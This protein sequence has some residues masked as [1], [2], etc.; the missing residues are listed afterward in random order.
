VLLRLEKE[1]GIVIRFIVGNSADPEEQ[2]SLDSEEERY[3][4][5][6]RLPITVLPFLTVAMFIPRRSLTT[7]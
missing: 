7:D 1:L 3:K 5:F 2:M 6:L 4:D